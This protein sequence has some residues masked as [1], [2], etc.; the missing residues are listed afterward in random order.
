VLQVGKFITRFQDRDLACDR[1][2]GVLVLVPV[3]GSWCCQGAQIKALGDSYGMVNNSCP[4]NSPSHIALCQ[5]Q[6][7]QSSAD[8]HGLNGFV[9]ISHCWQC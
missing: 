6:W 2:G 4:H 9:S 8:S 3:A 1:G 7:P 5:T